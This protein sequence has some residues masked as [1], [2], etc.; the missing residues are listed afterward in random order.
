MMSMIGEDCG[1]MIG[2]IGFGIVLT[3][4]ANDS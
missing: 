2:T 1:D 4:S 3:T